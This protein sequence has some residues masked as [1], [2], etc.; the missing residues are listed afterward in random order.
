ML[1]PHGV[2]RHDLRDLSREGTLPELA[3]FMTAMTRHTFVGKFY[4]RETKR[5]NGKESKTD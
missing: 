4:K 1:R 5:T 3:D 2:T